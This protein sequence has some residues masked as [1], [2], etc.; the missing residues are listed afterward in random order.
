MKLK[1]ITVVMTGLFSLPS[2]QNLSAQDWPQFRGP[3]GGGVLEKLEHPLEWANDKNLA[4]SVELPGGG[5]SSPIVQADRVFLTTAIGANTPVSF[6]EGVRDMRP[7]KPESAVKF[8]VICL[9]LSDGSQLWE[10]TLL[11]KQP[12]FPIHG[13]NSYATE[14]PATDGKH[15]FVYYAAVGLIAALD[16]DGNEIWK[17]E[18]GAY[19]TGNG[20]GTGSSVTTGDGH[21]FIQCD[22]DKDS[23][24]V[25]FNATTGDEVWRK[26]RAGKTSWATPLFWKNEKRAELVT[27]G[28][29]FVTS[30]DPQTGDELWTLNGI[31]M[32][33][34][35]SPAVDSQ[36]IYFGNSGPMSSGPLVA[37]NAGMS[38]TH[39]FKSG[40]PVENLAWSKMQAGPGM[41][42]PVSVNGYLY[43]PGRGIMTCYWAQDGTVAF[44]ERL[45][46]GSMAASLWAA[47]DRVF[48]M[49]ESGKTL[50]LQTGPELK[51]VATN[52]I[53]D[54][55]FWSTPAVSGKSL[56]LRG[57]KKLY[58]IRE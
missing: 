22:N 16:F 7:K 51:V 30:Y 47:G 18:I 11:E 44:K 45:E 23:F 6:S 1:F 15:L 24:V 39:E 33:F 27:C 38:G 25:A 36:R 56:L 12:E 35:A 53:A 10:N 17:Q 13:S 26:T 14:S 49:D 52:Q 34:S 42:S 40:A 54:D 20:F 37:V 57:V 50:V 48:L 3:Q 28:A 31:G 9:K 5:L 21:V 4:W 32:S 2:T 19:P 58:C 55:L 41:S 46:L 8:A 43:I 29:G